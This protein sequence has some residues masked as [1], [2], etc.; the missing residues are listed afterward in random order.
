MNVV[1]WRKKYIKLICSLLVIKFAGTF[2]SIC[3][4]WC[5]CRSM[6]CTFCE[7]QIDFV[8]NS[9]NWLLWRAGDRHGIENAGDQ[10]NIYTMLVEGQ[11]TQ[12]S[13]RYSKSSRY[14][15]SLYTSFKFPRKL[16]N[17]AE[18]SETIHI[19][20]FLEFKYFYTFL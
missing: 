14:V 1:I 6:V 10:L 20:W 18:I 15:D 9:I 11:K 16:S 17:W 2:E 4:V 8:R 7:I 13:C 5:Y 19:K 12:W 3:N